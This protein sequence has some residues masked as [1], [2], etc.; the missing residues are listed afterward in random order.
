MKFDFEHAKTTAT[1][2]LEPMRSIW[3]TVLITTCTVPHHSLIMVAMTPVYLQQACYSLT[4]LPRLQLA[5]FQ[6]S[7]EGHRDLP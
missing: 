6:S 7:C 1:S 4:P 3:S 2:V 5:R